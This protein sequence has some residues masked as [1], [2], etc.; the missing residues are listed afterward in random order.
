MTES[1]EKQRV[2][3]LSEIKKQN[4]DQVVAVEIQPLILDFKSRWPALFTVTEVNTLYFGI[5]CIGFASP[6]HKSK[7]VSFE[8]V[9]YVSLL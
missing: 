3:L 7:N 2:A 6:P 9:Y 5:S 8:I 1:Q 4:N